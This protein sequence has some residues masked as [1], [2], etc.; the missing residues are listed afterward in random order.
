VADK[1]TR[2]FDRWCPVPTGNILQTPFVAQILN[3]KQRDTSPRKWLLV[4][5]LGVVLLVLGAFRFVLELLLLWRTRPHS[6]AK[7]RI[8]AWLE[9]NC[10]RQHGVDMVKTPPLPAETARITLSARE[11][12]PA[13]GTA[14]TVPAFPRETFLAAQAS[15]AASV[16]ACDAAGTCDHRSIPADLVTGASSV[17]AVRA[18]ASR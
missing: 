5:V 13:R 14:R 7:R 10:T 2:P 9:R 15:C 11:S 12:E 4:P 1:T 16:R 17:R 18:P 8:P 3:S 6:L